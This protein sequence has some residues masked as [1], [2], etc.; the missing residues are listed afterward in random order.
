MTSPGTNA[1]PRS[2]LA[3]I[4]MQHVFAD[5]NSPW[6]VPR[7]AE[8]VEAVT[9]LVDAFDDRVTFSRFV[10]PE[11]PRGAWRAYYAE[12]PFALVPA[13]DALYRLVPAFRGYERDAIAAPSF[14]K[15]DVLAD[16]V[17]VPDRLVVCG[18]S[19]DCCVLSTVLAAAD[20]GVEVH[21]VADACAGASDE[22]HQR[23]LQAMSLYAPLVRIVTT[24]QAVAAE[25]VAAQAVA[26]P[27]QPPPRPVR[28]GPPKPA[29][30]E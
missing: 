1:A 22:T 10:A 23:A 7:F 28:S 30:R 17:G 21:V 5:P 20:A 16:L 29:G 13:E 25:A 4:D 27:R 6:A 26:G 12:W 15:W 11:L 14:G 8:A 3:V 2:R 18:V 24:E 19:T 9:R